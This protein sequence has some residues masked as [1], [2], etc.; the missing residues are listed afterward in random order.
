MYTH[1]VY[2]DLKKISALMNC[3]SVCTTLDSFTITH[4][5]KILIHMNYSNY[6]RRLGSSYNHP[7]FD[8]CMVVLGFPRGFLFLLQW[9]Y[10]I[11]FYAYFPS[12]VL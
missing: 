10:C 6:R 4:A 12:I 8:S 1:T 7:M 9:I 5:K 11:Y 3:F 2:R